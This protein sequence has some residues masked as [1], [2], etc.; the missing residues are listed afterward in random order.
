MCVL[1]SRELLFLSAFRAVLMRISMTAQLFK[2]IRE[3]DMYSIKV[4]LD[5]GVG[6]SCRDAV[7]RQTPA[8]FEKS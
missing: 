3:G 8:R 5:T 7:S 1:L 2:A 4:F 6:V